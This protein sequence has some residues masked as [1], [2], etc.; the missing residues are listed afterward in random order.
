MVAKQFHRI[1]MLLHNIL[2]VLLNYQFQV[3][4]EN[5]A[6]LMSQQQYMQ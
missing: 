1:L 6:I 3:D 4:F 5:H 2:S